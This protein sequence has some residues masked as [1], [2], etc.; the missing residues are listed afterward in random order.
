M[1]SLSRVTCALWYRG[2]GRAS[3]WYR[4]KKNGLDIREYP[5]RGKVRTRSSR[6]RKRVQK[7]RNDATKTHHYRRGR[8]RR[9]AQ[10][11]HRRDDCRDRFPRDGDGGLIVIIAL[12]VGL[13]VAKGRGKHYSLAPRSRRFCPIARRPGPDDQSRRRET[14]QS[15]HRFCCGDDEV[16]SP[17]LAYEYKNIPHKIFFQFRVFYIMK[18]VCKIKIVC[19]IKCMQSKRPY[20]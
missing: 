5:R 11:H 1:V 6:E 3:L 2:R 9:C 14:R 17:Y 15:R 10:R 19:K 12:S 20:S 16:E 7:Q 13:V 18:K 4:E 8:S